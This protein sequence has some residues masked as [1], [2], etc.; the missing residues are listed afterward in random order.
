MKTQAP[1]ALRLVGRQT[2]THRKTFTDVP[3]PWYCAESFTSFTHVVRD[4]YH[5]VVKSFNRGLHSEDRRGHE[6][7]G[8]K[9]SGV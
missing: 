8:R 9:A 7:T 1:K 6:K 2:D 5:E 4:H 3:W